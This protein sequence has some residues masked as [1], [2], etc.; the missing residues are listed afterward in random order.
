MS[1]AVELVSRGASVRFLSRPAEGDL[2]DTIRAAGFPVQPLP[3]DGAAASDGLVPIGIRDAEATRAALSGSPMDWIVVDHYGI[4][5][6]WE[7]TV[8]PV[9]SRLLAVDDLPVRDHECDLLLDMTL[10]RRADEYRPLIPD[11]ALLLAGARYAL[12]RPEFSRLR[13]QALAR[14]TLGGAVREVLLSFG[15]S[16]PADATSGVVEQVFQ[17]LPADCGLTVVSGADSP[18]LGSVRRVVEGMPERVRLL[19]G[20]TDMAER[21]QAADLAVGAGGVTSWERCC[22][23]L[24]TLIITIA[25]NQ[26]QVADALHRRGAAHFCGTRGEVALH[27]NRLTEP[28]RRLL[29]DPA[30]RA[31][32]AQ[33]AAA[34]TDG[35]GAARVAEAMERMTGSE[36]TES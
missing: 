32:M 14:R 24:P 27:P 10:D 15:G 21:M 4:D 13:R 2:S 8:R 36:R 7:R 11:G 3:S 1:L 12:L 5:A 23:G 33:R 22:L 6:T 26:Q 16:D 9:A 20:V 19:S 28:L 18:H 34:V 30:A 35:R 29:D 17:Q 25:A 31:T